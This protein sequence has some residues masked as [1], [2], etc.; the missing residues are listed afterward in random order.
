MRGDAEEVMSL[1]PE[2]HEDMMGPNRETELKQDEV[3]F[4]QYCPTASVLS[5]RHCRISQG[6]ILSPLLNPLLHQ[7]QKSSIRI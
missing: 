6:S 7:Q 5:F 2:G 1:V 3:L 4:V